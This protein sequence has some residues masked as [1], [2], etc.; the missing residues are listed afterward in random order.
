MF[1]L[2]SWIFKDLFLG[3][4]VEI[5]FKTL[6][7]THV[8]LSEKF[9]FVL[10]LIRFFLTKNNLTSIHKHGWPISHQC[11]GC[12]S[13]DPFHTDLLVQLLLPLPFP[14][15]AAFYTAAYHKDKND[16]D[17]GSKYSIDGP[18]WHCC[19]K[20]NN[21]PSHITA[22]VQCSTMTHIWRMRRDHGQETYGR[23]N[24]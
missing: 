15:A 16:Q 19:G 6:V 4:Y 9:P 13:W 14:F 3:F 2:L 21:I 7:D 24:L 8:R 5:S 20:N 23:L 11:C 10:H 22:A 1:K 17:D 12:S 18:S